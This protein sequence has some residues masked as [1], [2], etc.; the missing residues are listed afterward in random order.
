MADDAHDAAQ[1]LIGN[2]FDAYRDKLTDFYGAAKKV[3]SL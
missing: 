3:P 2:M 1:R